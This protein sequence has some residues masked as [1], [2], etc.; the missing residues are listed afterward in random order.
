MG[1]ALAAGPLRLL[2]A[3]RRRCRRSASTR[4]S[5]TTPRPGSSRRAGR[6]TSIGWRWPCAGRRAGISTCASRRSCRGC[7][8]EAVGDCR[9][10]RRLCGEPGGSRGDAAASR[11]LADRRRRRGRHAGAA[12]LRAPHADAA[13]SAAR[14]GAGQSRSVD[15]ARPARPSSAASPTTSAWSRSASATACSRRRTLSRCGPG[16]VRGAPS[17]RC[18]SSTTTPSR[19]TR[20]GPRARWSGRGRAALR[21]ADEELLDPHPY[22]TRGAWCHARVARGASP[23][24]RAPQRRPADSGQ[25][26]PAPRGAGRAAAHSALPVWCGTRLT[27]DWHRRFNVEAVIYGHLHLRASRTIDGVRFEEVSLGYPRQWDQS[28][29]DWTPI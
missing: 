9:S 1:L 3:A 22:L 26:L 28:T 19:P 12:R 7:R 2:A 10:A 11:R 16:T 4:R 24:G 18:S 23:A 20:S 21:S 13:V 15:A 5:M 29:R 14:L 8:R 6:P 25:P 17:C 27:E